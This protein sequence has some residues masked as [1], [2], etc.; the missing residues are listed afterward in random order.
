MY[1]SNRQKG[2]TIDWREWGKGADWR[3]K[4]RTIDKFESEPSHCMTLDILEI[5]GLQCG[6]NGTISRPRQRHGFYLTPC[7]SELINWRQP[8]TGRVYVRKVCRCNRWPAGSWQI[9]CRSWQFVCIILQSTP[10]SITILATFEW[11]PIG[12]HLGIGRFQERSLGPC[13]INLF[14]NFGDRQILDAMWGRDSQIVY[15]GIMLWK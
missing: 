8:M 13:S 15:L 9:P 3:F 2:T 14:C 6:W 12:V 1:R 10:A 5:R 11:K 4:C 7:P